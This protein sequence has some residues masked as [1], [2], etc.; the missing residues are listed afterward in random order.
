MN[1][2]LLTIRTLFLIY[3]GKVESITEYYGGVSSSSTSNTTS[4]VF[5]LVGVCLY[6]S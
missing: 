1:K 2:S 5:Q 3:F 6:S 4:S